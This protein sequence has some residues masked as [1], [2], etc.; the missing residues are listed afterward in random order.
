MIKPSRKFK[1]I[2]IA[3]LFLPV[4]FSCKNN[5]ERLSFTSSLDQI[6]ALINQ[7]QYREA[8]KLLDK[9]EKDAYSSWNKLGIFKR[10]NKIG[11]KEKAEKV[12]L[13]AIKKNPENLELLAVYSN[14]LTRNNRNVEALSFCKKL[15]GTKYGSVYSEA[16]F[17]DTI[18]KYKSEQLKVLFKSSEYFPVY[19]D[20]Y[21]GT[22]NNSWLRNCALLRL[23]GGAYEAAA[24]INPSE[25]FGADDAFFWAL[26]MYDAKRYGDCVS[27][28]QAARDMYE[29]S[30]DL[31]KRN[32]TTIQIASL[33]ADSYTL[34]NDDENAELV[35]KDYLATID[36][37]KG[38]WT[39]AEEE[40]GKELLPVIFVNS[41]KWA[42]A[43]LEDKKA[44]ALLTFGVNQWKDY[45]PLLV[46]YADF[47]W[48]SSQKREEDFVS[49]SLRDEG[50][51]SLEM[52]KYD[53]RAVIPVSDAVY[54]INQSLER[55]KDPLLSV[56]SLDL[57]YKTNPSMNDTER[58]ADLW[59]VLEKNAIKPQVFPTI[60]FDYAQNAFLQQKMVNE[61]WNI[62]SNQVSQKYNIA[63]DEY[64]WQ[65]FI[66]NINGIESEEIE[67]GAYYSALNKKSE[68]ALFLYE[69]CVYEKGGV[70]TKKIISPYATDASVINLAMIYNSLGKTKTALDL[71]AKV[72]GRCSDLSV[73]S[74]VMYRMALIYFAQNDIKNARTTAEYAVTL[75]PRNMNARMLLSKITNR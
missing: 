22:K 65:N 26:V 69:Y 54:R 56:V 47:A 44:E 62:F 58:I 63:K 38:S 9:I 45:V 59:K 51:A 15:Q 2:A 57:R 66:K 24:S 11:Q 60:L 37:G 18:E 6:D 25:V 17:R 68:D 48:N 74:L 20:A 52:E 67:Y 53:N 5:A 8:D 3:V 28:L 7:S 4:F 61:A 64:F 35:R 19:Y 12:L 1:C 36:N 40:K 46:A 49:L 34:L 33:E 30:S 70:E 23:S 41:A 72:S 75:D 16:V 71:Y 13:R 14:F 42:V 73:K 39:I 50:I 10:Y 43:N 27:Y 29:S 55:T 21:T 31:M 32:V